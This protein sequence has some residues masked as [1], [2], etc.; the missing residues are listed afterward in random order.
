MTLVLVAACTTPIN[1][2]RRYTG[3]LMGCEDV[4]TATLTRIRND[5]AFTPGDSALVIRGAIGP[6]GTL[7]GRFNTQ[8]V[9]KPAY[10][11]TVSGHAIADSATVAYVT[12]RCTAHGTLPRRPVSVMP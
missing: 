12:P 4:M 2:E 9:G 5:F 8:P 11:L 6:D 1:V 10:L 3:T 7:A